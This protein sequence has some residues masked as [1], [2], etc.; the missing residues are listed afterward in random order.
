[1]SAATAAFVQPN[2]SPYMKELIVR[3][4]QFGAFSPVFRTHG[5]RLGPSEPDTDKCKP[6]QNSCGFNEIWSY[7]NDTEALLVKMVEFRS[8]VLKPYIQALDANV[9]KFGVPTMRPLAYEFPL[10]QGCR[11]IDDQY[12]LGPKYLVAPV[13]AQNAT[14]RKL[15]FPAGADWRDVWS[16]EVVKGGQAMTVKA[17]LD[18]IPAYERQPEGLSQISIENLHQIFV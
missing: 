15:Y 3:W 12:M 2:D 11:G 16:G 9:T 1:M 17:P 7:G 5:C 10:D 14:T 6:A 4:Y 13:T 8:R 18:V